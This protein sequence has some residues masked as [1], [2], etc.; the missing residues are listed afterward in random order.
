VLGSD[1][2]DCIPSPFQGEGRVRVKTPLAM[3]HYM[4]TRTPPYG[5]PTI[6]IHSSHP[7][8][9]AR[10]PGSVLALARPR[11]LRRP[12]PSPAFRNGT[13]PLPGRARKDMEPPTHT[14]FV[15]S[16]RMMEANDEA[17]DPNIPLYSGVS[18]TAGQRFRTRKTRNHASNMGD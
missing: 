13:R 2:T 12:A 4:S 5:V 9:R 7:G 18:H 11:G 1:H 17:C 16:L 14:L 6:P 3:H 8:C 10:V 15:I